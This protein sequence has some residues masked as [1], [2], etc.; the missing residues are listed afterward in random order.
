[1]TARQLA[2]KMKQREKLVEREFLASSK[3]LARSLLPYSKNLLTTEIYALPEDL[4]RA[5]KKKWR[6]TGHLRRSERVEVRTPYVV[7]LV[8]DAAYAEP[9]HEAGKPG[10]R[11]INPLRVSHWRDQVRETFASVVL[12]LRHETVQ[13]I[14][15]GGG[16][17]QG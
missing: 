3:G 8:N 15:R 6:R 2:Q 10:R 11:H 9:R 1:M 4:T 13:A 17:S 7:A 5:G 16:S 14:L 12:D